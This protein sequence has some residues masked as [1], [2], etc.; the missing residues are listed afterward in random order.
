MGSA[1][2]SDLQQNICL[3]LCKF[4]APVKISLK[5]LVVVSRFTFPFFSS[6]LLLTLASKTYQIR[7]K[8]S[9]TQVSNACTEIHRGNSHQLKETLQGRK[10]SSD[11]CWEHPLHTA[12]TTA[13]PFTLV[14][15]SSLCDGAL[16][17]GWERFATGIPGCLKLTQ[18][19]RFRHR[20][21]IALL[22]LLR[23]C[24][25]Q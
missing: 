3:K 25:A 9:S 16:A 23:H 2:D 4:P 21:C 15:I 5:R 17:Q 24:F 22:Y 11:L 6:S 8:S 20:R 18:R 19:H 10:H 7:S 12:E 13:S 1:C 14:P